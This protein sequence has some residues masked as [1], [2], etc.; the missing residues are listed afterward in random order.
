MKGVKVTQIA[1][2]LSLRSN[3]FILSGIIS[4]NLVHNKMLKDPKIHFCANETDSTA[5]RSSIRNPG[6]TLIRKIVSLKG[7]DSPMYESSTSWFCS[8]QTWG[9]APRACWECS[10]GSPSTRE[11]RTN[12]QKS[13]PL[14]CQTICTKTPTLHQSTTWPNMLHPLSIFRSW[15]K[16]EQS[17]LRWERRLPFQANVSEKLPG[18]RPCKHLKTT[19]R[20]NKSN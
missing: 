17:N 10:K 2:N 1:T 9:Q 18:S 11:F 4:E 3:I 14:E 20:H 13:L 12:S 6:L 8:R 15:D 7:Q 19:L 5:I 16:K